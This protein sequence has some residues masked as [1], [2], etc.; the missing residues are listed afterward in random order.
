MPNK[1]R[2]EVAIVGA[3]I[4]GLAHAYLAARNGR[5]VVVFERSPKASGASIRNF[6]MIWPLGQAAGLVHQLAV[7]SREL[8]LELLEQGHLPFC[9]NGALYLAYRDDEEAVGQEFSEIGPPS[10]YRCEWI[11]PTCVLQKTSAVKAEGL[12]GALWGPDEITVD[13]GVVL[14]RLPEYLAEQ[15]G[16]QFRFGCAVRAVEL[17]LIE[18]GTECWQTDYAIILRGRRL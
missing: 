16:V 7:R 14:A 12:R 5:S 4:V 1:Q 8:W 17:P 18:A 13:P 3:G 15:R 10:G 2:A 6:G 11:E 9:R